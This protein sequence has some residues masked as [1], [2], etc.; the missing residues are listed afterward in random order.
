MKGLGVRRINYVRMGI[1]VA[2][3]ML[4]TVGMATHASLSDRH[5]DVMDLLSST[6]RLPFAIR[7][8]ID[9]QDVEQ[10]KVSVFNLAGVSVFQSDVSQKQTL[11]WN[12][13]GPKGFR[14]P[15][16]IY[17]YVVEAQLNNGRQVR[18]TVKKIA[19]LH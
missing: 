10:F 13:L 14:V 16:G 11:R 6:S 19:V 12:M 2:V 1:V 5:W 9:H 18:N 15:N 7:F 17:L 4:V 8:S 3:W